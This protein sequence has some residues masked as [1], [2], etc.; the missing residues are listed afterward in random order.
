MSGP[1]LAVGLAVGLA[2][3]LGCGPVEVPPAQRAAQVERLIEALGVSG[4]L[5]GWSDVVISDLQQFRGALGEERFELM[6]LAAREAYQPEALREAVVDNLT[7]AYD[8]PQI[9]AILDWFDTGVGRSVAEATAGAAE[10]QALR[11]LAG[12]IARF[13]G[14]PPPVERLALIERYNAATRSSELGV[15]LMLG[16]ARGNLEAVELLLPPDQRLA[17]G[18]MNRRLDAARE[19]LAASLDQ[20]GIVTTMFLM[21]DLSADELEAH[22]AFL[23]GPA[24]QWYAAN[25]GA[26]LDAAVAAAAA[27]LRAKAELI[28]EGG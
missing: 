14:E 8:G 25:V 20:Q 12:F 15:A 16:V 28:A 27:D 3:A 2:G 22:V 26:A 4:G 7:A 1:A 5:E 23:E 13:E 21:R 17:D 24:F 9:D 10:D 19:R 11:D 18:E 6:A